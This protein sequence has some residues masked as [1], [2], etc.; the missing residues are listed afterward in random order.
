M[1]KDAKANIAAAIILAILVV[2]G[3]FGFIFLH[4]FPEYYKVEV[5][6]DSLEGFEIVGID[7]CNED[8]IKEG[9]DFKFKVEL[10]EDYQANSSVV[11][12]VN[13]EELSKYESF[14]YY[15]VKDV[16]DNIKIKVKG[17]VKG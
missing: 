12:Y 7:G 16:Q 11:V 5:T 6:N 1:F 15:L 8:K 17:L 2:G 4:D 3:I 10:S 9:T 13:G 14:D